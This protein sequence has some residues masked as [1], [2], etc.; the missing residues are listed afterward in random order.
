MAA[1][2]NTITVAMKGRFAM[3]K[4]VFGGGEEEDKPLPTLKPG[5]IGAAFGRK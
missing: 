4:A 2:V 5:T 3:L 1:D